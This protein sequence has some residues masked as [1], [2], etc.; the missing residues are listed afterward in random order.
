MPDVVEVKTGE[1]D[2]IPVFCQRA[3]LFRFD[4]KTKEWKEKGIG[5]FK[6][7]KHKNKCKILIQF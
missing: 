4:G 2:E 3:K 5:E 6:I 7:L 1:E